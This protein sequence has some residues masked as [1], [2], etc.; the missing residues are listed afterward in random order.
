MTKFDIFEVSGQKDLCASNFEQVTK[1][2]AF[3]VMPQKQIKMEPIILQLNK[4]CILERPIHELQAYMTWNPQYV[5]YMNDQPGRE[6][7]RML[8]EI[9]HQLPHGAKV[10][11]VGT[12]YGASAL[13]LSSNPNI[14]VTT[15]DIG[16]FIPRVQGLATPL[17]RTNVQM[18][19][20]SGQLDIANIATSH[21]VLLDIDPHDGPEETKF[22]KLLQDNG[23]RG[24]LACDDIHLNDGMKQFWATIPEQ[25]KKVDV[26]HL[27]HWTGTGF[28]IF[29]PTFMDVNVE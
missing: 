22:V 17:T 26:S 15:Y 13:A 9:S 25:L 1:F 12:F 28:V 3:K 23:F 19:V 27:A 21:F 8:A 24:V 11:D 10:S 20:M 4:G 6:H 16:Q 7:Y 2:N 18:K 29:D 14:R 5:Q